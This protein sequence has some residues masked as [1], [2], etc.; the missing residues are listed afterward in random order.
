[1]S[2]GLGTDGLGD[3][4]QRAFRYALSLTHD[5]ALAE[6]LLQ[7]ACVGLSRRGGPWQVG[8]VLAAVRHRYVDHCR[9]AAAVHFEPLDGVEAG[10]SVEPDAGLEGSMERALA[11]LRPGEREAL[12]LSAVE[13][14]STREIVALTGRPRG[15]ILSEIHRAKAKLRDWLPQE[16]RPASV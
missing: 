6:D 8:Y 7:D 13:G 16:A 14:M 10:A 4:L 1:V 3:V 5:R 11:R 2:T 15:S 12:F 9:R